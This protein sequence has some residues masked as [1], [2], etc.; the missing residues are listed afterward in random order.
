MPA[1]IQGANEV[2]FDQDLSHINY[3]YEYPNGL[4]LKP[5]SDL[6]KKIVTKLYTW[7]LE[8]ATAMTHRH[9]SWNE[10]DRTLTAYIELDDDESDLKSS[11]SRKPVSI[12]FPFSYAILETF[13]S[14]LV[15]AFYQEPVFRYEGVSPEDTV[16]AILLTKAID[17]QCYKSKALLNLHTMWRDALVYG[18]GLVGTGWKTE[19]TKVART[20]NLSLLG[21]QLPIPQRRVKETVTFEGNYLINVDPYR[22]I[23]DPDV[24]LTD[25][26]DS[27]FFG[28]VDS[29]NLMKMLREEMDKF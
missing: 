21:I 29:S 2:K 28:W 19:K 16:G 8:G 23:M 4:D 18:F 3:D 15:A 22:T 13:L 1:I 10:I 25:F 26:Q 24:S 17:Q 6:H 9:S 27:E 7:A 20:T 14:Y 5:G 12:V 11:D